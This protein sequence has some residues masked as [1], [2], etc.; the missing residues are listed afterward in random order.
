[1]G[2]IYFEIQ[3]SFP[4]AGCV[5]I[6]D[7]ISRKRERPPPIVSKAFADEFTNDSKSLAPERIGMKWEEVTAIENE[8]RIKEFVESA[9]ARPSR[10]AKI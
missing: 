9:I 10:R 8:S 3:L 4:M 5:I 6:F 2:F 1:M 7:L